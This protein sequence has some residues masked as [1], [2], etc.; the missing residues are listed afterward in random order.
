MH[1]PEAPLRHPLVYDEAPRFLVVG[2][3]VFN[4][5]RDPVGLDCVDIGRRELTPE[6]RVVAGEGLK[7]AAAEG[8]A[9]ETDLRG[10]LDQHYW[11][12]KGRYTGRC[13][14]NVALLVSHFRR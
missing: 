6:V 3:K 4:R 10:V 7:V 9:V 1:L 5:C 12:G 8:R 14:Q 2:R 11:E 13:E